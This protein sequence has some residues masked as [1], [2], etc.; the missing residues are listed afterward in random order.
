MRVKLDENISDQLLAPLQQA[1]HDVDTVEQE[2][3]C[4]EPDEV[5]ATAARTHDRMLLTLDKDFADIR[6]YPPGTHPGIIGFRISSHLP[7][8][9][10]SFIE[11]FVLEHPLDPWSGC[12]VIVD[13][14]AIRVRQPGSSD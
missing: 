1:G 2:G 8:Y 4:A 11:R 12:L 9:T 13:E 7:R 6:K 3:L 5:I 14:T 10:A